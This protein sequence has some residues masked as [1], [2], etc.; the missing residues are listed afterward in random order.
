MKKTLLFM[1]L[2]CG[3]SAVLTAQT[4][5]IRE[6]SGKVEIKSPGAD[7]V[8]AVQG[9]PLE[10]DALISTGLKS[11]ALIALGNSV[12][13]VRPLTR[14]TLEEL[15]E[16]RAEGQAGN[17]QVRLSLQ[18]GRIRAEVAPPAG[19][20]T[21]FTVRSPSATA[22]VRGTAFEFDGKKLFVRE[23]KVRLSGGD[24]I[25]V[26]VSAGHQVAADNSTGKTPTA[27]ETVKEELK[28]AAPAGVIVA[29]AAIPS[30]PAAPSVNV[31]PVWNR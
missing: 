19:G 18:T 28:P 29:P 10:K 1:A 6:I 3:L 16:T 11:T 23:G 4:A 12:L 9:Q 22:S 25:A 2:V 5:T 7:W 27:V 21:S 17:E 14:L 24:G 20:K 26:Y 8:P 31:T 13:T 15:Q 30:Q